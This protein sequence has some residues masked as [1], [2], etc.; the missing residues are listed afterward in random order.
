MQTYVY[1]HRIPLTPR[2]RT[3]AHTR[4]ASGL[5]QDTETDITF[6]TT[7]LSP[8]EAKRIPPNILRTPWGIRNSFPGSPVERV[9]EGERDTD[10]RKE[11][12]GGS[13]G[14]SCVHTASFDVRSFDVRFSV[15]HRPVAEQVCL[16]T[17]LLTDVSFGVHVLPHAYV[18]ASF[19]YV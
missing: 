5:S 6:D 10:G 13:G 7:P 2:P 4:R 12:R 18:W 9:G 14:A 1:T 3:H 17:S 8:S 16:L 11:R 15:H 19:L